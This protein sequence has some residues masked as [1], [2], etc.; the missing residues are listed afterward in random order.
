VYLDS[1]EFTPCTVFRLNSRE[2]SYDHLPRIRA[3][4]AGVFSRRSAA[5]AQVALDVAALSVYTPDPADRS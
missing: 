4:C 1:Q 3:A 2:F 5:S